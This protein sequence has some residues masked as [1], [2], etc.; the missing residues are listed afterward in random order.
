MDKSYQEI[1]CLEFQKNIEQKMIV[2]KGFLSCDSHTGLLTLIAGIK[3]I[4]LL[5]SVNYI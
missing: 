5:S 1:S 3:N 2:K 4:T